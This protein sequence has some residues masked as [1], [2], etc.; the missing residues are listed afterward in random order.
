MK[1]YNLAI[2]GATGA[3]GY[4][5]MKVLAE[6][7]FPIGE[8]RLLASERSKGCLLYTSF[9]MENNKPGHHSPGNWRYFVI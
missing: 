8:L 3:V 9:F 7:K 2:V 6:R 1:Q 5:L 4:E